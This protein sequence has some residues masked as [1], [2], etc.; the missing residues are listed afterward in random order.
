MNNYVYDEIYVD[1]VHVIDDT[2]HCIYLQSYVHVDDN[3]SIDE[4]Y[5]YVVI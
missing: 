1:N 3:I 4:D 2:L 5:V